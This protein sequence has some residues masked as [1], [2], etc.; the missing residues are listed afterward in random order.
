MRNFF[1]RR[2]LARHA[3]DD[4]EWTQACARVPLTA[5]LPEPDR[6][7]LRKLATLLLARKRISASTG[8]ALDT[9][10]RIEIALWAVLPVLR[11]GLGAYDG[12]HELIIYPD[13]FLAPRS[14]VDEAG[15][16]HEG[17]EAV[18]GEAWEAGPI[19]L[20]WADIEADRVLDGC[21]V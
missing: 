6:A 12:F 4:T 15:V 19:L 16:V 8:F 7:R 1:R 17:Y 18:C 9:L 3:L 13:E 20:S 14:E 11:I 5:G 2:T 21:S 10:Q